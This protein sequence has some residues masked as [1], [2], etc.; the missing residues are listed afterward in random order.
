MAESWAIVTIVPNLV[1]AVPIHT[2]CHIIILN[3]CH[4]P[5]ENTQIATVNYMIILLKRHSSFY[6]AAPYA[7]WEFSLPTGIIL[8][9]Y[10]VSSSG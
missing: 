3:N 2:F 6:R 4:F 1:Q 8:Q 7:C 10:Q 5:S 9:F